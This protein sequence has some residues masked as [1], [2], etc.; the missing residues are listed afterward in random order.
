M[1]ER[2]ERLDLE[3]VAL[4]D[5]H[6]AGIVLASRPFLD[7]GQ[8]TLVARLEPYEK[9]PKA[10]AVHDLSLLVAEQFRLDE[11]AKPEPDPKCL[12]RSFDC[13]HQFDDLW[14]HIEL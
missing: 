2:H 3:A 14:I 11:A 9:P 6:A 12:L 8:D 7:V 13:L 10:R 5:R 4:G 1:T